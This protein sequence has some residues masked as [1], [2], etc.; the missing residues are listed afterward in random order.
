[1]SRA[2]RRK[3]AKIMYIKFSLFIILAIIIFTFI[4]TSIARYRSSG[5]STANVDLAFYLFKEQSISQDLKLQSI[6]PR[7]TPY[8]YTFSVANYNGNDRTETSIQYT[9]QIK[10]TTNLPLNFSI[11][12]QNNPSENLILRTQNLPD[13]DGT[14][15]KYIDVVGGEFGFQQN[16]QKVYNLQVEFPQQYNLAEYEGIV[17]YVQITINSSQKIQ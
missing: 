15:F 11:V 12:N 13:S 14:Y 16:E 3:K 1:M 4:R 10:T 9:I 17:E 7:A 2:R 8:N 6:L 5:Q